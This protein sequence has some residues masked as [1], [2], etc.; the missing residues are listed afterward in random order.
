MSECTQTSL[1][2]V[3]HKWSQ[4]GRVTGEGR[5]W[6]LDTAS[7]VAWSLDTYCS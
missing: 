7:A 6:E 3:P 1:E 4:D 5:E 2:T